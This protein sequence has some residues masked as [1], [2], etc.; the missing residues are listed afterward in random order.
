MNAQ[1]AKSLTFRVKPP[2]RPD[3]CVIGGIVDFASRGL[4]R[5]SVNSKVSE[6]QQW[7]LEENGYRLVTVASPSACGKDVLVAIEW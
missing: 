6:E 5:F 3:D 1:E 7:W 2:Q 4:R